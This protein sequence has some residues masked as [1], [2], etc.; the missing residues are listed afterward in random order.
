MTFPIDRVNERTF[1]ADFSGDVFT[2]DIDRTYLETRFSSLKGLA[3]IPFEFAVDKKDI[4]GMAMLLREVRRGPGVVSRHTPLYFV[5]ASPARLR[6]VIQR[7]MLLDGLEYDGT[8]FKDWKGVL[9]SG[10]FRRFKEQIGYKLTALLTARIELPRNAEEILIGDDLESDPVTFALYADSLAN[11]IGLEQLPN[12]LAE[13]G[14]STADARSICELRQ[15]VKPTGGVRRVFV[16]CE[17][18][19]PENLHSYAPNIAACSGAIQIAL[20]LLELGSI[21]ITG[22]CRV[23]RV[24]IQS[25]MQRNTLSERIQDGVKRA[26]ISPKL[27]TDVVELL[28][29]SN[30]ADPITIV[31]P[32]P[33]WQGCS[34]DGVTPWTPILRG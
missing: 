17:R 23:I 13:L 8:T 32:D 6:P 14:V 24:L 20:G 7:K 27:A 3:R 28:V 5:S 21:S 9:L 18:N 4:D 34:D 2:C 25:G 26:V 33:R 12:V 16:R 31:A 22:I 10:R 30:L 19:T 1:P 11:R 15:A 29:G